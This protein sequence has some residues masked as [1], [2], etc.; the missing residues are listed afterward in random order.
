MRVGTRRRGRDSNGHRTVHAA[1]FLCLLLVLAVGSAYAVG[2]SSA[3]YIVTFDA[4]TAAGGAAS[5]ASYV[6]QDSAA[7]QSHPVG[8]SSSASYKNQVGVFRY[9]HRCKYNKASRK[10]RFNYQEFRL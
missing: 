3:N 2:R 5:S 4:V 9:K 7:G 1:M 8:D 6:E 10:A